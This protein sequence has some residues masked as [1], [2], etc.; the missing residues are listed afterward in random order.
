VLAYVDG[1]STCRSLAELV[2][3]RRR[4]FREYEETPPPPNRFETR[5]SPYQGQIFTESP[6]PADGGGDE[7]RGQGCCP[8]VVRGPVRVVTDPRTI[9]LADRRILVAEH[10]DPGW[11]LIF[12]SAL[13][14]LV[15][16]GSLLSHAAIVTRE[17]G[18]PS[19][20][21]I[22]GVTRW[23]TDG[24]WVEMDGSTGVVRKVGLP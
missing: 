15:E 14:V 20:V 5:G 24:D 21:A 9:D 18:I 6:R 11:I 16:R 19:I 23:L 17:L 1:R 22:P 12:P 8:G 7:R 2:S 4:E 3:I 13:G 10:T